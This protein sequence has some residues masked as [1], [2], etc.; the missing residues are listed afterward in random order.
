MPCSVGKCYVDFKDVGSLRASCLSDSDWDGE[1]PLIA[2]V[3]KTQLTARLGAGLFAGAAD[4]EG[5]GLLVPSGAV[6]VMQPA[7]F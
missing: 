1:A 5:A 3:W 4:R 6:T 7:R 2:Q